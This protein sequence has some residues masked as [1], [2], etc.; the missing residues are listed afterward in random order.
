[1]FTFFNKK[2][3]FDTVYVAFFSKIFISVY[4]VLVK[5]LD[6]GFFEVTVPLFVTTFVSEISRRL[7]FLQS[8]FIYHYFMY[9]FFGLVLIVGCFIISGLHVYVVLTSLVFFFEYVVE[10]AFKKASLFSFNFSIL[11]RF[12]INQ[13]VGFYV[14][15]YLVIFFIYMFFKKNFFILTGFL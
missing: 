13:L 2:F 6:K 11:C 7:R 12:Y 8:G 9:M 5:S 4:H 15:Y 3:F 1:L 10:P 14:L